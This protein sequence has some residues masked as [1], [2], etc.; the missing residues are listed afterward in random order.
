MDHY[1]DL[2]NTLAQQEETLQFDRFDND[3]ALAVGL[4]IVEEVR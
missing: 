1:A 3:T 4:G 2:L